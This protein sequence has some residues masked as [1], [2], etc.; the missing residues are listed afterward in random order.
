MLSGCF[1]QKLFTKSWADTAEVCFCCTGLQQCW[2]TSFRQSF[3]PKYFPCQAVIK[4]MSQWCNLLFQFFNVLWIFR[5]KGWQMADG[6]CMAGK[7]GCVLQSARTPQH[8]GGLRGPSLLWINCV[9]WCCF[10][11]IGENN[12]SC[13][14]TSFY[15]FTGVNFPRDILLSN[16]KAYFI[17][18]SCSAHGRDGPWFHFWYPVY[19]KSKYRN[20]SI[21][22][23]LKP[24]DP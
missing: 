3:F 22:V 20:I 18:I 11:V 21:W 4:Q 19:T 15:K 17:N 10:S 23:K 14:I 2:V 13:V 16:D 9:S 6:K 5:C 7:C 8:R 1:V 24:F 12:N